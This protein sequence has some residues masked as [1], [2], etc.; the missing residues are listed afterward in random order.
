MGAL[1]PIIKKFTGILPIR[2][3][4]K[5]LCFDDLFCL[6][7]NLFFTSYAKKIDFFCSLNSFTY[8]CLVNTWV[9]IYETECE[10]SLY[11]YMD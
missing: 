10:E 2:M 11:S 6:F 7:V 5:K 4:D 1:C 3:Y 9:E 8:F